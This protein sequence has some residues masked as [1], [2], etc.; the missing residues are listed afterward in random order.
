MYERRFAIHDYMRMVPF[1]RVVAVLHEHYRAVELAQSMRGRLSSPE[2]EFIQRQVIGDLGSRL[3]SLFSVCLIPEFREDSAKGLERRERFPG[4][5]RTFR[6]D[7]LVDEAHTLLAT[8]KPV[9]DANS[10]GLG[11]LY[12]GK[13]VKARFFSVNQGMLPEKMFWLRSLGLGAY[14]LLSDCVED[15]FRQGDEEACP[16]LGPTHH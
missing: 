7:K 4:V 2:H 14:R 8:L 6:M 12:E 5:L 11:D 16:W 1:P 13:T 3:F 15:C 10:L 9:L